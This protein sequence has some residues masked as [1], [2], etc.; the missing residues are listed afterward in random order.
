MPQQQNARKKVIVI[1]GP[2]ATG[3]T[4]LSVRLAQSLQ[5][6]IIS[7]DSQLIYRGLDIG[8]AKPTVEEMGGVPHHLIDVAS[9]TEE[10]TVAQYQHDA[11]QVM[12][13]LFE[14][15]QIP[16]FAGGTGFYLKS[17]LQAPEQAAPV[18]PNPAFREKMARRLEQ[19]GADA[20][21]HELKQKD[22]RRASMLYPQDT[23]RV[24]RAL[25]IIEQ[26]GQ[27][28]PDT[29]QLNSMEERPFDVLWVVLTWQNREQH[30]QLIRERVEAM[31]EAG[32]LDEVRQLREEYGADAYALQR[33]H[34]YPVLLDVLADKVSIDEAIDDISIQVRQ[35]ARRQRTWFRRQLIQEPWV[36][37]FC[38]D[39]GLDRVWKGLSCELDDMIVG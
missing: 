20:L 38:V 32:W 9:P 14:S 39:D 26:T 4:A 35:Y 18:Q 3:K 33:S 12:E 29:T 6:E 10:Y 37:T 27:L 24:I 2:T 15:S 13:Q 1:T 11:G 30:R 36:K 25:E 8:T 22:P 34:G 7:S 16:V 5:T 21:Y 19:E 31:L 23:F 17:V 28:V